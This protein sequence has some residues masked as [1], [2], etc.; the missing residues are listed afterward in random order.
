MLED[1]GFTDVRIGPPIDTFVGAT[2]EDKARAY[3]VYGYAFCA[4]RP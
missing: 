2:G 3:D 4:R 1:A